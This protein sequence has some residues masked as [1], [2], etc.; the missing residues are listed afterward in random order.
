MAKKNRLAQ[1]RRIL[2]AEKGLSVDERILLE[3]SLV[4]TPDERWQRHETFLRS[5]GLLK[6]LR[7]KGSVSK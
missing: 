3:K 7:R 6:P 1:V 4:A 2:A 5:H